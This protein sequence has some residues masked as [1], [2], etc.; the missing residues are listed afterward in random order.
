MWKSEIDLEDLWGKKIVSFSRPNLSYSEHYF[1][2]KFGEHDL[3]DKVA[4][5]ATTLHAGIAGVCRSWHRLRPGMDAGSAEP[6]LR[7]QK[8]KERRFQDRAR[9]RLEQGRA[10]RLARRHHR[11]RTNAGAAK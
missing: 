3:A 5:S 11:Y 1:A 4:I 7:A 6:R 9:C 2:E 10:N 8:G